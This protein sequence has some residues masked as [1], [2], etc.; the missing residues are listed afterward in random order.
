MLDFANR[1][2][3]M[4][5]Q[6]LHAAIAHHRF[7]WIH[8]FTNGNGNGNGRVSRL[9]TNAMLLRNGFD[10]VPGY[11][12]VNPTAVF[13]N[14]RDGY[15]AALKAADDLSGEGTI[16]WC[17]FFV[18]GLRDDLKRL[19][20]MHD[21]TFVTDRLIDPAI[22]RLVASGGTS[23]DESAALKIAAR[24]GVVKAGDLESALTGSPSQRSV[25]IRELVDR[26][27]LVQDEHGPRFYRVSLAKAPL[28][29]LV[30]RQPDTLGYL[31]RILKEDAPGGDAR[32]R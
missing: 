8:P 19:V 26:G 3:P 4:H 11:R 9:F 13:G 20:R 7:A 15:Y 12:A 24:K 29:P 16:A 14:D 23:A 28:A 27:L 2:M 25:A 30:I 6:M 22:D 32:S 21:F 31:P 1:D 17:E 5:E 18:R 10:S